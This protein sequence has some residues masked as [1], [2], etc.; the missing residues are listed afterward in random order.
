MSAPWTSS[1]VCN[2]VSPHRDASSAD[3]ANSNASMR[4]C[5]VSISFNAGPNAGSVGC[6]ANSVDTREEP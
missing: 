5:S 4:A 2:C 1:V 3:I 6:M